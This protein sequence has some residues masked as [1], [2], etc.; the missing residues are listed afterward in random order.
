MGQSNEERIE[1]RMQ[2]EM[3]G[4]KEERIWTSNSEHIPFESLEGEYLKLDAQW[5]YLNQ[6]I[7]Q[8]KKVPDLVSLSRQ[9]HF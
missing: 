1:R 4:V 3:K 8:G 2:G 6:E 7:R 9:Q 5:I